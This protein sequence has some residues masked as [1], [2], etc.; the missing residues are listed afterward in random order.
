M[1]I[2]TVDF[3]LRLS[4]SA[5]DPGA[6]SALCA[7]GYSPWASFPAGYL[8]GIREAAYAEG[9]TIL[10]GVPRL[11]TNQLVGKQNML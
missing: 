11:R 7:C 5:G 2:L 1:L 4:L 3:H 9:N 10:W 6:S 8:I